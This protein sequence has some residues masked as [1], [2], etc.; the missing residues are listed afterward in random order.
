MQK[1]R[2]FRKEGKGWSWAPEGGSWKKLKCA[3]YSHFPSLLVKN[4]QTFFSETFHSL[5]E[6]PFWFFDFFILAPQKSIFR[7]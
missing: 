2:I 1:N 6:Y 3:Y 7:F 4:K 5:S